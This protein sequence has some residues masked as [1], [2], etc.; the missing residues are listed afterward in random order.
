MKTQTEA[1][2][3]WNEVAAIREWKMM[4]TQQIAQS[5]KDADEHTTR[6]CNKGSAHG[7]GVLNYAASLIKILKSIWIISLLC[8]A[9]FSH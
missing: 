8:N 2:H 1:V 7:W 5:D 4:W 9:Y 6:H 3:Q